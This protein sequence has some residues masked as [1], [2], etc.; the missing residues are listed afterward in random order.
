[1]LPRARK[2]HI[3]IFLYSSPK[4]LPTNDIA[5]TVNITKWKNKTKQVKQ[6]KRD[7]TTTV[8]KEKQKCQILKLSHLSHL[9]IIK[10]H[11]YA[12][13]SLKT[14]IGNRKLNKTELKRITASESE[15]PSNL[16]RVC[17]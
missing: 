16:L 17:L 1:M 5:R 2:N 11:T 15:K 14:F 10:N 8:R 12:H 6:K 13:F 3:Q 4:S 9:P 7:T